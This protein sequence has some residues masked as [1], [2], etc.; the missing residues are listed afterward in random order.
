M[1]RKPHG[2]CW[3]PCIAQQVLTRRTRL[4]LPTLPRLHHAE[5]SLNELEE[6][7]QPTKKFYLF[8]TPF[9]EEARSVHNAELFLF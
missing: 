3:D 1:S 5:T 7:L 4:P 6:A 9:S 8:H 2:F